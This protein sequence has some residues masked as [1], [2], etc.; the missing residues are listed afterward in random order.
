MAD[1]DTVKIAKIVKKYICEKCDYKCSNHYDYNKHLLTLKHQKVTNEF[2][3]IVV[4]YKCVCEKEYNH[5]QNLY[6]HKKK[7]QLLIQ[8]EINNK[9]IEVLKQN[10]ELLMQNQD[11]K[12]II[13][14]QKEDRKEL[15]EVILEQKEMFIEQSHHN[16]KML[17]IAIEQKYL[18]IDQAEE[19]TE[20]NN[21]LLKKVEQ[22]GDEQAEYNKKMLEIAIEQ[23][24]LMEKIKQK[25][26]GN[27]VNNNTINNTFNLNLFLNETCKDAMNIEDLKQKMK[28]YKISNDQLECFENGSHV[29]GVCNII[30]A[31]LD[32]IPVNKR[33]VHCSDLKREI[34]HW[35]NQ[36]IWE[37][38]DDNGSRP[39]EKAL[40]QYVNANTFD[41]CYRWQ[42]SDLDVKH[43]DKDDDRFNTT[44]MNVIGPVNCEEKHIIVKKKIRAHIAKKTHIMHI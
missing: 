32:S 25:Q 19:Q 11:L 14:E 44:I 20:H 15:K 42:Q 21:L 7:C 37:K 26:L 12:E 35:K 4:K 29:L 1:N 28:H 27:T 9:M 43:N 22:N 13:I 23:K 40:M 34:M 8:N 16:K 5:R 38:E 2:G 41:S 36:G 31:L 17:E 30:N 3:K 24:E 10:N 39:N 18:A 33:P 6:T